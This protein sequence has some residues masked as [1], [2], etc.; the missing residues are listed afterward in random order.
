MISA[1]HTLFMNNATRT[2]SNEMLV[3][4]KGFIMFRPTRDEFPAGIEGTIE[5]VR[6][7]H[8]Y[9]DRVA[10]EA[11]RGFAESFRAALRK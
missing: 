10:S 1:M 2:K 8:A 5:F 9:N 4:S 6:A 3:D 11:N 7:V